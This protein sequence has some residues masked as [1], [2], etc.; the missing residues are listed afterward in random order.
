MSNAPMQ[1]KARSDATAAAPSPDS[2]RASLPRPP[3]PT[4]TA[5]LRQRWRSDVLPVLYPDP[6]LAGRGATRWARALYWL[7][8][9]L[10]LLAGGALPYIAPEWTRPA[11]PAPT[12]AQ[13]NSK[14]G[15][16]ADWPAGTRFRDCRDDALCPW[17]RVLP[18]DKFLMGSSEKEQGHQADESPQHEVTISARFAVMEAEVT[19]GQFAQFVQEQKYQTTGGCYSLAQGK[20]ELNAKADWRNPG[21]EQTDQHPVV[22]INW[23]DASAYARWLSGKTGKNYRLL[24]EA[25]WEYAARAGSTT[26][27]SFGDRSEDLCSH[28]NVADRAAKAQFKDWTIAECGDG[29]VYTAPVKTYRPNAWGLYDLHGNAWEWVAD[30]LHEDYKGAPNNGSAWTSSCAAGDRRVLRG[31]GWNLSPVNTRSAI[32]LRNAPDNRYSDTG[33]RL[34]RT[35]TP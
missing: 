8:L 15:G 7:L 30:C 33:F 24:S 17:L 21:F 32:R 12:P 23:N 19:R 10:I 29:F 11:A 6:A 14:A 5:A 28:A 22:C 18:A 1:G 3:V 13:P 34:A 20:F 26:R 31:G 25:E 16:E 9:G 35:L 4:S 27:Y 2:A